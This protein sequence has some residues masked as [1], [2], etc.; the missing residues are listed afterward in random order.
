M[1]SCNEYQGHANY[2]TYA[3]RQ[4]LMSEEGSWNYWE[5]NAREELSDADLE[6]P[7]D[8][9][10]AIINLA[11]RMSDECNEGAPEALPENGPYTDVFRW[12]MQM[13]DWREIAESWIEGIIE[14]KLQEIENMRKEVFKHG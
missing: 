1:S 4:W 9:K 14:S 12:A 2:P 6:A 11:E 7:T 13:V 5:D 8:V 3:W 10:S